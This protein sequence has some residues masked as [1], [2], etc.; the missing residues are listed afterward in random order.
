[1]ERL[2]F[3]LQPGLDDEGLHLHRSGAVDLDMRVAPP[4]SPIG[5]GCGEIADVHP[6]QEGDLPI[7]RQRLPVIPLPEPSEY[8]PGT[9]RPAPCLN[10]L[11]PWR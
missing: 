4:S 2:T 7:D 10:A 3:R 8:F 9:K 1:M 5:R 6:A 11:A